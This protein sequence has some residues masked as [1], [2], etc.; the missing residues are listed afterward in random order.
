MTKV[1][2]SGARVPDHVADGC[3]STGAIVMTGPSE[4]VVDFF[5]DDRSTAS[6]RTSGDRAAPGHAAVH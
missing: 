2:L 1:L 5:A 4:Y 3:F 6:R